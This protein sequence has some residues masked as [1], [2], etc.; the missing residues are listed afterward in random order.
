M[1]RTRFW[2][3]TNA[4]RIDRTPRSH[5]AYFLT[6]VTTNGI[7]AMFDGVAGGV[8]EGQARVALLSNVARHEIVKT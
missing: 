2:S 6:T 1:R 7:G 5:D 4:Q 3:C 8:A